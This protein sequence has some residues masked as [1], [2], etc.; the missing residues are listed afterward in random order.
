MRVTTKPD[1]TAKTLAGSATVADKLRSS[2]VQLMATM[3]G[4]ERAA[5]DVELKR[6]R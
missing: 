4:A 3:A 6:R 1:E 2:L 5:L